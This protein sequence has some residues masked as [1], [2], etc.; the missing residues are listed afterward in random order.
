MSRVSLEPGATL[1]R[2]TTA[3][4]VFVNGLKL[5]VHNAEKWL[6]DRMGDGPY[7]SHALAILRGLC[8]QP[9][10]IRIGK[11]RVHI[12]VQA[13]DAP[14]YQRCVER[15]FA[16]LNAERATMLDSGKVIEFSVA[17]ARPGPNKGE[18]S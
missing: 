16:A 5:L 12:E 10:T 1:A 15:L 17:A 3:R 7:R 6:A 4:R 18:M 8:D 11:D 9:G 13:L 2:P 14:R